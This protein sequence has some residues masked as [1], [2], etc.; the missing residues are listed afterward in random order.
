MLKLIV[1]NTSSINGNLLSSGLSVKPLPTDNS[2]VFD[3]QTFSPNL[4]ILRGKDSV[5]DL[6]CDMTLEVK[7]VFVSL[8]DEGEEGGYF[9]P[10]VSANFPAIS[11]EKL[12]KRISFDSYIQG[13]L[14]R[15]FY[16]NILEQLLLFCHKKEAVKLILNVNAT[17]LDHLEIYSR[18]FI[19]EER[20]VTELGERT[21]VIIPTDVHTYDEI[22]DFMDDLEKDFKKILW[23][24]QKTNPA[25]HEYLISHACA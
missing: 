3:F 4:S 13:I 11:L 19:S 8:E 7:E 17:E 18:F 20:V 22:I 5:H 16:L 23:R 12:N 1:N 24:E 6:C 25:F 9:A 14:R 15:Q 10:A 21:Q 2:F